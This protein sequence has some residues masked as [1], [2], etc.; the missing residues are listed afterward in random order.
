MDIEEFPSW[1]ISSPSRWILNLFEGA[2]IREKGVSVQE[3][4]EIE[5]RGEG[6]D[7]EVFFSDRGVSVRMGEEIRLR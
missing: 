5:V 4:Y 6:R 2:N 1:I 3:P 7:L